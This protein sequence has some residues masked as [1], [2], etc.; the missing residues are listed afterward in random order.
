VRSLNREFAQLAR[1]GRFAT[2][3]AFTYDAP[4][5]R[6]QVCNA[7]HPPP[8]VFRQADRT[9]S[10]LEQPRGP[11]ATNFPLGIDDVADY[12]Q[13][14]VPVHVG[15]IVVCYTDGLPESR[16]ADR[17][18]LGKAALLELI[19]G[20]EGSQLSRLIP[21][22]LQRLETMAKV[23]DDLTV[24]VFRPNGQRPFV[25]LRDRLMA[26]LNYLCAVAAGYSP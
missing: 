6:L 5:N 2:A 26:P 10:Y 9:W 13:F 12:E 25:P 20:Q 21:D 22:L 1:G 23:E 19:R 3:L 11:H 24:L 15:D 4:Q 7:G 17:G 18:L 14:E 16:R 8:L